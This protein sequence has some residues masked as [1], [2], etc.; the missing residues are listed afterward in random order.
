MPV[1][2][3]PLSITSQ[4]FCHSRTLEAGSILCAL[5]ALLSLRG[6][7]IPY[8]A[9]ALPASAVCSLALVLKASSGKF[10]FSTIQRA[11]A[12]TQ[13]RFFRKISYGIYLLHVPL[14]GF[15]R[16]QEFGPIW[17]AFDC[18]LLGPLE[19]L[20]WHGWLLSFPLVVMI[21]VA[22]A[23][24]LWRFVEEPLLT[25]RDRAPQSGLSPRK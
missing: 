19:R 6:R 10:A 11:M 20:R 7:Y 16:E 15:F 4:F 25:W 17:H 21:S 13:L 14:G 23:S 8:N 9:G 18:S 24:L 22:A 1:L 5:L 2:F 12:S 3:L